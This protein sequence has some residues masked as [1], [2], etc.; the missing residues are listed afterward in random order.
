[1]ALKTG[2]HTIADLLANENLASTV[3]LGQ[4]NEVIQ[5][6]VDAHNG[7]VRDMVG[8]IAELTTDRQLAQGTSD[9]GDMI[10]G[11][12]FSRPPTQKPAGVQTL[13][14]PLRMYQYGLG[15]TRK[16]FEQHTV[17][18]MARAV[19]AAEK[20]HLKKIQYEL[21]R[22][23]FLSANFSFVDFLVAPNITLAVKRFWNADSSD[24]PEGPNG[25]VFD[26]STH[27]HFLA[28]A[29]RSA[30]G[31]QSALDT[32]I[33]HGHGQQVRVVIAQADE[34]ATRAL[35]GFTAYPDPRLALGISANQ[36]NSRL[37]L[38]RLDNR[39][40]GLFGQAEVWVKP[41]GIANYSLVYDVATQK[42]VAFRERTAGTAGLR[43]VAE[44][45][46]YP[47]HAKYMEAEF[48]FGVR[49]RSNGCVMQHSNATYQ[50]P[51]IT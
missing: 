22:A 42:P 13:G 5:A 48:G 33:E 7:I 24:I 45:D 11:D 49:N 6:D 32:V 2:T 27:T 10:E 37:D 51:T 16:W 40:I 36:P 34:T 4:V 20:A 47:L 8:E 9:S 39:A 44:I 28:E 35:T 19:L 15:W 17:A 21:K 1:M 41:W 31:L 46:L 26:G 25:E 50:D 43:V 30:A 18:E 29:T 23:V 14:I 12:E 38:T 3:D